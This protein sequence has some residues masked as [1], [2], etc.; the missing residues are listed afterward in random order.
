MHGLLSTPMG[1]PEED[2]E[3][4]RIAIGPCGCPYLACCLHLHWELGGG[5][6][7]RSWVQSLGVHW[8]Q[9][10]LG[11]RNRPEVSGCPSWR[12][13]GLPGLY[14]HGVREAGWLVGMFHLLL[15]G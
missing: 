10:G 11:N 3:G 13:L 1:H 6:E 2:Q 8:T 14:T 4:Y 12:G 5:K 15:Q 9:G 7:S